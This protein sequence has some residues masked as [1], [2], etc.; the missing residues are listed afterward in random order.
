MNY[1]IAMATLEEAKM[2]LLSMSLNGSLIYLSFIYT[3]LRVFPTRCL[4][5][6]CR[7]LT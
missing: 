2:G 3:Q 6:L 5:G 1:F 7:I 4:F